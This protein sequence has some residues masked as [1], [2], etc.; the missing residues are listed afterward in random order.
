M[1]DNNETSR[2]NLEG[3]STELFQMIVENLSGR[4]LKCLRLVSRRASDAVFYVYKKAVLGL[5]LLVVQPGPHESSSQSRQGSHVCEIYPKV[6]SLL[7]LPDNAIWNTKECFQD[8]GY[9]TSY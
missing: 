2:A 4:R 6:V 3:L 1:E 8:T 7:Q 9:S 5:R